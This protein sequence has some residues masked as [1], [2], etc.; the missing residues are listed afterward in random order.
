VAKA[1]FSKLNIKLFALN[2]Y[3]LIIMITVVSRDVEAEA[4]SGGSG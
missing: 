3:K 4:G 2:H 1:L